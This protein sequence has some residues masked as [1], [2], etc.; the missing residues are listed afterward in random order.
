[1]QAS[2]KFTT[3]IHI[4][5][6]L[7]HSREDLVSSQRLAA[8]VKTNPVVIRRL[9]ADLKEHKIIGSVNGAR[10]GFHLNRSID[11]I[12]LWDIYGA[13]REK[14]FFNKPKVNPDCPVSSNLAFL[15]D[16][17]YSAAELSMKSIMEEVTIDVLSEKLDQRLDQEN[18]AAC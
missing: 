12:S 11:K 2:S 16:D 3:A 6:F 15:V 9:I 10:G 8:S 18:L 13:V 4:C 1:M 17:V 14:N 7:Q 5:I